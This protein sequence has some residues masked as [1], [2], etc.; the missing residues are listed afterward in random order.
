MRF[1]K[2][3]IWRQD[4]IYYSELNVNIKFDL[5]KEKPFLLPNGK[6]IIISKLIPNNVILATK[7]YGFL[8][9]VVNKDDFMNALGLARKK[10][11]QERFQNMKENIKKAIINTYNNANIVVIYN[12][13]L[14]KNNLF[15]AIKLR[16]ILKNKL[17]DIAV[18]PSNAQYRF[19][20]YDKDKY[21]PI[22]F[23]KFKNKSQILDFISKISIKL[24]FTDENTIV[25][26]KLFE[27]L[28]SITTNRQLTQFV[29]SSWADLFTRK[30][31]SI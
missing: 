14:K 22:I 8:N 2:H 9:Q 12:V 4:K 3:G 30:T 31:I 13:Q 23:R 6:I 11:L 5:T 1:D 25:L 19:F 20:L 24:H 26:F 21:E 27:Q 29:N 10:I 16:Q 17:L 15:K 18:N 7:K 28:K